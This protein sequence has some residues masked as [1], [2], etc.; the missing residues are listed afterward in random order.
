METSPPPEISAKSRDGIGK[1][2]PCL[3]K[4]FSARQ[5]LSWRVF[6]NAGLGR[7]K[8]QSLRSIGFGLE[9]G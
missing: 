7:I 2:K 1:E 3:S 5:G 4:L 6:N 9:G 8:D